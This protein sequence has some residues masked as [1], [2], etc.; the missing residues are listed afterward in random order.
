MIPGPAAILSTFASYGLERRISKTPEQFG[1]GAIEGVAGPEAANN[2]ATAG[3]MVPLLALG[4]PF[5]PPAA[6]LLGA[7]TIHGVQPGPLLMAQQPEIFWGVVASMYIGNAVLLILN[8]PLVGVFAQTLRI[9]QPLLMGLILVLCLVGTFSVNN[10][11]LD[12]FILI[13]MGVVGYALRKLSFDMAPLVLALV[14][15]PTL[16]KT[17][18]QSLYMARGDLW[19]LISRPATAAMLSAGAAL[20]AIPLVYRYILRPRIA[21]F[22]G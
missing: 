9:P 5:A 12:I 22:R 4:I 3:S 14:L 8:L 15:G 17:F 13:G 10:S 19:L 16:E 7:L 1:H 2:A 20:V 21:R 6:M 18:R 11:L